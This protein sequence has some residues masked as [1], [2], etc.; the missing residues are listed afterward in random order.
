M[1]LSGVDWGHGARHEAE[2]LPM[3]P[4]RRWQLLAP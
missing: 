2:A 3:L 4:L 1:A